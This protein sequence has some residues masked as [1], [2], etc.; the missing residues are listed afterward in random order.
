MPK[1]VE[2][3]S[4][5]AIEAA[6][7]KNWKKAL[8]L[9]KE[10]LDYDNENISALNRL[11][12]AY[13][14]LEKYDD[15]KKTLKNVLKLDPI[16]QTAKKN[17]E[18]AQSRRKVLGSLPHPNIKNF[19][20]EPGTTKEFTFNILTKGLTAKKFYLGEPIEIKVD[21]HRVSL[22][23]TSENELI[24]VF[25]SL[26]AEKIAACIKRGGNVKAYYLS[27]DEKDVTIL[28]KTSIPMFKAEKQD[29]KPYIKRDTL[30][31]PELEL[32]ISEPEAI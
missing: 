1:P 9:N 14:E 22:H 23:K 11:A 12:K 28:V 3:L 19:I 15:T 32:S 25:D 8:I 31:E 21:G 13:L 18:F 20:K 27:G 29:V 2:L 4:S 5:E 26:A 30:E 16:N 17:M 10:I 7:Q 6:L 24:G